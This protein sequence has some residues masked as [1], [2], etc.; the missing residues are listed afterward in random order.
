MKKKEFMDKS[1]ESLEP[2]IILE[3]TH[4]KVNY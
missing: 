4:H 1:L 3:R 2:E